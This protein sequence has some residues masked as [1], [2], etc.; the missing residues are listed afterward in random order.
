MGAK[1]KS[2][3]ISDSGLTDKKIRVTKCGVEPG[4]GQTHL[5]DLVQFFDPVLMDGQMPEMQQIE[6]QYAPVSSILGIVGL[7]CYRAEG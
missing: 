6:M 5:S 3:N 7:A 4:P 2:D 1:I